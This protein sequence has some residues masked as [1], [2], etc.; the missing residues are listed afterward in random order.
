MIDNMGTT[1]SCHD[2]RVRGEDNSNDEKLVQQIHR[3]A[4][5][6]L[7]PTF[8]VRGV[9]VE[10]VSQVWLPIIFGTIALGA[11]GYVYARESFAN[12]R[13]VVWAIIGLALISVGMMQKKN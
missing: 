2:R 1:V 4:P 10:E 12:R 6:P 5:N 11:A 3:Y 8:S 9:S 13:A 7:L